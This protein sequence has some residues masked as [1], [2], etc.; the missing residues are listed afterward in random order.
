MPAKICIR[1]KEITIYGIREHLEE[2]AQ[3]VV[4]HL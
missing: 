4:V 3:G 1:N 2:A